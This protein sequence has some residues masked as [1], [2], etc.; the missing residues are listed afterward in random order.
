MGKK[1]LRRNAGKVASLA[2]TFLFFS[3]SHAYASPV[4][5]KEE[6]V[7]IT[8]INTAVA[9]FVLVLGVRIA[10]ITRGGYLSIAFILITVGIA[11]SY[12]AH[13]GLK[14]LTDSS[15]M[16]TAYDIAGIVQAVGGAIFTAGFVYLCKKLK[17]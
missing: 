15:I 6:P 2:L 3:V 13:V 12:I 17:S 4:Y 14:F 10:Y 1:P 16:V 8:L 9:F 11:I 7:S 5:I